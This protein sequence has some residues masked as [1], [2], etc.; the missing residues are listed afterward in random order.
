MPFQEIDDLLVGGFHPDDHIV[1][2]SQ[3]ATHDKISCG[4][5]SNQTAEQRAIRSC[6]HATGRCRHTNLQGTVVSDKHILIGSGKG[7]MGF[8]N[9]NQPRHNAVSTNGSSDKLRGDIVSK[10]PKIIC[11]RQDRILIS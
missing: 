10:Y 6:L 4:R 1:I 8:V 5:R 7:V 9:D 11:A 2:R 3:I